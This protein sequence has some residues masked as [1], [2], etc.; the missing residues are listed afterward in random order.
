LFNTKNLSARQYSDFRTVLQ[1]LTY[2]PQSVLDDLHD[3]QDVGGVLLVQLELLLMLWVIAPPNGR[4][5]PD[6]GLYWF[7]I[8]ALP[9]VECSDHWEQSQGETTRGSQVGAVTF[10][11]FRLDFPSCMGGVH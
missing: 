6:I 5:A 7:C 10:N 4:L 2:V 9:V 8:W 3:R 11:L 1:T